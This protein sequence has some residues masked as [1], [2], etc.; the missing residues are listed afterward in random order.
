MVDDS[1]YRRVM[2]FLVEYLGLSRE[3]VY[4]R[5]VRYDEVVDGVKVLV[6]MYRAGGK[7]AFKYCIVRFNNVMGFATPTCVD[8][9]G[10]ARELYEV[11]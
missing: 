3:P 5:V 7:E 1:F 9:E 4:I 8:D 2:E 10:R 6:A 11:A